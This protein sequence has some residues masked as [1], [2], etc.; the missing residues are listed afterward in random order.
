MN[1]FSNDRVSRRTTNEFYCAGVFASALLSALSILLEGSAGSDVFLIG[2]TKARFALFMIPCAAAI[3]ALIFFFASRSSYSS[4]SAEVPKR[5]ASEPLFVAHL[6]AA[7]IFLA[8]L[9]LPSGRLGAYGAIYERLKAILLLLTGWGVTGTIA[10]SGGRIENAAHRWS[11]TLAKSAFPVFAMGFAL[12]AVFV[13]LTGL[14]IRPGSESWY[15]AAVP[16]L[17]EQLYLLCAAGLILAAFARSL[18]TVRISRTQ[19]FLIIWAVS[20]AAFCALPTQPHFFAP[21]P[22]PPDFRFYPYSDAVFNDFSARAA[23]SG[24]G[25]SYGGAVMKPFPTWITFLLQLLSG[26]NVNL[27]QLL[28]SALFGVVPALLFLF[29]GDAAGPGAGTIAAAL[30]VFQELNAQRAQAILT[31]HSRL[32][33]SEWVGEIVF[34]L[35][36]YLMYRITKPG[37]RTGL[38]AAVAAGAVSGAAIYTRANFFALLPAALLW[39]AATLFRE[40]RRALMNALTLIVAAALTI[41]PWIVRSW[42]NTHEILPEVFGTFQAV[43]VQQR[44][45]DFAPVDPPDI[46]EEPG[47]PDETGTAPDAENGSPHPNEI[48]PGAMRVLKTW[49]AVP[50]HAAEKRPEIENALLSDLPSL[51]GPTPQAVKG[52]TDKKN[53]L[54]SSGVL[55]SVAE[56]VLSHTLH[57][58]CALLFIPP[59]SIDFTDLETLFKMDRSP[60][61]KG[62]NGELSFEA[63]FCLLINLLLISVGLGTMIRTDGLAGIAP[64]YWA[65]VYSAALGISRTSGGRYVVPMNWIGALTFAIGLST[66][67]KAIFESEKARGKS[68]NRNVRID[69][70][71]FFDRGKCHDSSVRPAQNVAFFGIAVFFGLS[72]WAMTIYEK[73]SAPAPLPEI[74]TN[75]F[76][77]A[78]PLIDW[79]E[80]LSRVESGEIRRFQGTAVYPRFYF[81]QTGE[82]GADPLFRNKPYSRL[83]L[84]VMGTGSAADVMIPMRE[85]P[86]GLTAG[87]AVTVFGCMEP[88]NAY[89]D[90]L[91]LVKTGGEKAVTVYRRDP[92]PEIGC[93]VRE[94][95]CP[96]TNQCY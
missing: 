91:L 23:L 2:L 86:E 32:E 27:L 54:S 65:A 68:E 94:P 38:P 16:V 18:P 25:F 53:H 71:R 58:L 39:L 9:L 19:Q 72:F 44:F 22:Y 92:M 90:A 3:A 45:S 21:G 43:V 31:V 61:M 88:G 51:A 63:G 87:D 76:F 59:T 26:Y 62:W 14:G 11:R 78:D 17:P 93:P 64:L 81:Y 74:S 49:S 67:F 48:M 12:I 60:W 37:E 40:K 84:R 66:A 34:I 15:E 55:P 96:E 24:C 20:A 80:L 29:A 36:A 52:I 1:R 46:E 6:S 28:Q 50:A 85:V 41:S 30:R 82:H 56:I 79:D 83:T 10:F 73:N 47:V 35:F 33:M 7:L 57:N 5:R 95:I 4:R 89:L 8:G 70:K 69:L 42:K 75:S 13:R 77:E